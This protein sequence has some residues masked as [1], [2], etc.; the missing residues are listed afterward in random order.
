MATRHE[1][2]ATVVQN[3]EELLKK[4]GKPGKYISKEKMRFREKLSRLGDSELLFL[5]KMAD[6]DIRLRGGK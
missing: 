2:I 6:R 1:Q 3:M 4:A 5:A